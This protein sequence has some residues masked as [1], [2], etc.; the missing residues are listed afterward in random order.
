MDVAIPFLANLEH[1]TTFKKFSLQI[2][3]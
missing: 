2:K 3:Y 1:H